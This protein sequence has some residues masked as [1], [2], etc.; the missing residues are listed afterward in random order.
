MLP[1]FAERVEPGATSALIP[2]EAASVGMYVSCCAVEAVMH[3]SCCA[4]PGGT[5]RTVHLIPL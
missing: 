1:V 3:M 2:H 4:Y 5:V